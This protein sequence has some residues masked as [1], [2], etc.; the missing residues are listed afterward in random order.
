MINF[1]RLV[2]KLITL[3]THHFIAKA[4]SKH[5]KEL[6]DNLTNDICIVLGDFSENFSFVVQDEI[7]SFHWANPQATLH[8]YVYYYRKDNQELICSRSLCI[9]SDHLDHNTAAVYAFQKTSGLR[10]KKCGS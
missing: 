10:Y 5:L 8:P 2:E 7:Q 6:K 4:Q 1:F 9:I 3:K